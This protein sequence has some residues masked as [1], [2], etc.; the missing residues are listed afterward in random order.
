MPHRVDERATDFR[1]IDRFD[2][3]VGWIAHPDETMQRASHALEIEGEV[4]VIDPV[5]AAELDDLLAEFGPV[6]GVVVCL[7]RHVRDA[8]TVANRHDVPVYL[9]DWFSGV[10]EDVDAPVVRFGSELAET[11][12]EA[13]PV[14]RSRFW[15]EVSLYDPERGTLVVPESVGTAD[16]FLAGSERLGVHPMLRAVPP[17]EALGE[18][19]PERVLVGHGAGVTTDA[20]DALRT[21]LDGARRRAPLVYATTARNL[22]PF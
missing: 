19:H 8:A 21:A 7:D 12:I 14:H 17:R 9:P 5:D 13:R 2:G 15:Q 20:A 18:F 4:W 10:A 6:A 16:Y 11:G 1:E 3:G 22:L